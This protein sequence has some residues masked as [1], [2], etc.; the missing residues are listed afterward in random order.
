MFALF[1]S[2]FD[3]SYTSDD[4]AQSAFTAFTDWLKVQAA[5][6]RKVTI[7]SAQQWPVNPSLLTTEPLWVGLHLC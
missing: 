6:L 7:M 2:T 1:T 3:R 5:S 4:H